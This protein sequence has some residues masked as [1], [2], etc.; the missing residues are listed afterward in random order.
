MHKQIR[1]MRDAWY[2]RMAKEAQTDSV[3]MDEINRSLV[4]FEK[5]LGVRFDSGIGS[6]RAEIDGIRGDLG[7]LSRDSKIAGDP[8]LIGRV[9]NLESRATA[10]SGILAGGGLTKVSAFFRIPQCPKC[11][12]TD[13][14][15]SFSL[16]L[17]GPPQ[18]SKYQCN[19][20]GFSWTEP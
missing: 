10:V 13:L 8:V 16:I 9:Q 17:G 18:P 6:L 3:K 2:E 7:T 20:C 5:K 19:K 15:S 11:K 14:S 12:S 4:K 1:Q